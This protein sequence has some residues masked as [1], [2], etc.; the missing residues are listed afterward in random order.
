MVPPS[1]PSEAELAEIRR[2]EEDAR[3]SAELPELKVSFASA[4]WEVEV[5]P[6]S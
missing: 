6:F 2:Q 4:P 5:S 3:I 1:G